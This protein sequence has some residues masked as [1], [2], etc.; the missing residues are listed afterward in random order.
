MHINF[1]FQF[2]CVSSCLKF[3]LGVFFSIYLSHTRGF[4]SDGFI[5]S[6]VDVDSFSVGLRSNSCNKT[7]I[8]GKVTD[9]TWPVFTNHL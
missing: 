2:N 7:K 5:Q 8:A 4:L 9:C 6:E 3:P 1:R